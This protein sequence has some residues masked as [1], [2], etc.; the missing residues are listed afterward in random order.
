M[1]NRSR[2]LDKNVKK[3][4]KIRTIVVMLLILVAVFIVLIDRF[5]RKEDRIAEDGKMALEVR[6]DDNTVELATAKPTIQT[7][8]TQE[9]LAV[10]PSLQTQDAVNVLGANSTHVVSPIVENRAQL[11]ARAQ[12]EVKGLG[13]N[14]KD[15]GGFVAKEEKSRSKKE[16]V[17][18]A[19]DG[20][21]MHEV[22]SGETLE[23]IAKKYYGDKSCYEIIKTANNIKDVRRVREGQKLK[24]PMMSDNKELLAVMPKT[25]SKKAVTEERSKHV[26]KD[27]GYFCQQGQT[28][29][30]RPGE[31]L[32]EIAKKSGVSFLELLDSNKNIKNPDKLT[33]GMK[34]YIP[35]ASKR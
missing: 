29:T 15:T 5:D 25:G 16:T 3:V 7:V 30:V 26:S 8:V 24:I 12:N 4:K 20:E 34:I 35:V 22:K 21:I 13:A 10:K 11:L 31:S 14:N 33:T 17:L 32:S 27:A 23:V 19:S 2:T 28:H 9:H 6:A 18:V 1:T